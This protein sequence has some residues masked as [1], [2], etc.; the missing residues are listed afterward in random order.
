[1][2]EDNI[3]IVVDLSNYKASYSEQVPFKAKVLYKTDH[4]TLWVKS[5]STK[6]EY[7]I[8]T[9]QIL[10]GLD[11]DKLKELINLDKY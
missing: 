9:N 11:D 4:I 7:E 3:V 8:Y 2:V 5:L 10:E 6:K 1:M